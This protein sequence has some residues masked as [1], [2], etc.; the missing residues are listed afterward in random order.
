MATIPTNNPVPSTAPQDLKFNAEKMDLIVSSQEKSYTDRKGVSRKTWAAIGSGF[1]E[2]ISSLDSA[3][4]ITVPD[5]ASG[6]AATSNGQ[7]FR[8]IIGSGNDIAF[9]YYRNIDGVAV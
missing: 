9:V 4:V 6:L 1:D 2:I 8:K 5:E 3:G 7:Y